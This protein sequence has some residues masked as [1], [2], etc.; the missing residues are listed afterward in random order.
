MLLANGADAKVRRVKGLSK[1]ENTFLL[2]EKKDYEQLAQRLK[3]N[4]I[5]DIVVLGYN[6]KSLRF[7]KTIHEQFPEV[8][9]TVI[10][11]N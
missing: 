9:I 10:D 1:G 8:T 6:T 7:I 4:T 11:P 3:S 2:S 5:K